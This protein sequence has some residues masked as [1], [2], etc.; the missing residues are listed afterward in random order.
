MTEITTPDN[1]I[2]LLEKGESHKGSRVESKREPLNPI[3][4]TVTP[5]NW[6]QFFPETPLVLDKRMELEE[7]SLYLKVAIDPQN[8]VRAG[9]V[10]VRHKHANAL[11]VDVPENYQRR[12]VASAL[13]RQAQFDHDSLHLI[14]Y[15]GKVGEGLYTKM[16]FKP[17]GFVDHLIW[18]KEVQAKK[19]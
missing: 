12:G 10:E 4:A 18:K 2:K 19:D 6:S 14:N 9:S 11:S 8:N 15:A 7:G 1:E 16:D 5:D 13:I 17:E 3:I